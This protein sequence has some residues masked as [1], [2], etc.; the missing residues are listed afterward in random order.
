MREIFNTNY[1]AKK[2]VE[3]ILHRWKFATALKFLE[4]ILAVFNPALENKGPDGMRK[5]K[6]HTFLHCF[7]INLLIVD[8]KKNYLKDQFMNQVSYW[9]T[10]NRLIEWLEDYIASEAKK[11]DPENIQFLIDEFEDLKWKLN[12]AETLEDEKSFSSNIKSKRMEMLT[13]QSQSTANQVAS[14][15]VEPRLISD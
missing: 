15:S 11:N 13:K 8:N 3:M 10:M 2:S 12:S 1:L 4:I 6:K 14:Q 7:L 5:R 9:D